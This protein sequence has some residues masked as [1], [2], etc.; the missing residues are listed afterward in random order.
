V[1]RILFIV[2]GLLALFTILRA[3]AQGA[4][5]APSRYIVHPGLLEF[6]G[7]EGG[8]RVA[9]GFLERAD[10]EARGRTWNLFPVRINLRTGKQSFMIAL[11]GL[12]FFSPTGLV[13]GRPVKITG[14][15]RGDVFS[16]GGDITVSGNV[17]GDV[18]ALG[19]D[20]KLLPQSVVT[21]SA[22]AL[23]GTVEADRR[24]QVKGNK[25]S[26]PNLK[27]PFLGLLGSEQSAATFRFIIELLGVLLFLL[28]LFL[29]IHF[30]RQHLLGIT[31]VMTTYWRGSI[32]YLVLALLILPLI[33]A[34]LVVSILGIVMIPVV[35]V[36][37][38]FVGYVGYVTVAVRLGM[39][40]RR[41][42]EEGG[43]GSAYTAGLLG[44]LVLKGPVMLG[45][46]FSLLTTPLFQGIGRFLTVVG[47]IE[48]AAAVLFGL[49]GTFQ[50]MR[51]QARAAAG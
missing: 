2:I 51:M 8:A 40:L 18:W 48:V 45:I 31:G 36:A 41:G 42:Q 37:V 6:E 32:L 17:E 49:G 47:V 15:K 43:R 46:L 29:F 30:G 12:S 27:I 14:V 44:L 13:I 3:N 11:N 20:I 39:W 16:I 7:S 4:P 26:L 21:G 35:A 19:A 38:L 22:V 28:V 23:G 24:A 10:G 34:L 50:Y 5:D 1:R 9:F 33:V 25:Q